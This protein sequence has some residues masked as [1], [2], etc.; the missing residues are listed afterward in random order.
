[1]LNDVASSLGAAAP[2]GSG[3]LRVPGEVLERLAAKHANQ[4]P[5]FQDDLV[6]TATLLAG[7]S[8]IDDKAM[9]VLEE[10]SDT[11]DATASE[12]FRRL[13]RR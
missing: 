6:E 4:L 10:L 8:A 1:M 13:R 5:Y 11:A 9:K 3:G 12:S 2:R 7:E